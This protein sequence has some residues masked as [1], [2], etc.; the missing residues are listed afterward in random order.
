MHFLYCNVSGSS[1]DILL[2]NIFTYETHSGQTLQRF[3]ATPN[4][5]PTSLGLD[6]WHGTSHHGKCCPWG[7]SPPGWR[8]I[9]RLGDAKTNLHLLLLLEG[10]SIQTNIS[11]PYDHI[12]PFYHSQ[13]FRQALQDRTAP[14]NLNFLLGGSSHDFRKWLVTMAIVSPLTGRVTLPTGLHSTWPYKWGWPWL[15][16]KWGDPPSE[17]ILAATQFCRSF[18]PEVQ[19]IHANLHHPLTLLQIMITTKIRNPECLIHIIWP[20]YNISPT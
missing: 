6:A 19:Q 20:N 16:T 12:Y 9:F 17:N 14:R 18:S 4:G 13:P 10:G 15:L 7:K 5:W 1:S 3:Q 2:P 11:I 8:C